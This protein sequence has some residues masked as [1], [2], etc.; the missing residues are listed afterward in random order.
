M[1]RPILQLRPGVTLIELIIV[2]AITAL[3]VPA[4]FS[5]LGNNDRAKFDINTQQLQSSLRLS[6]N[7]AE[8]GI[9]PEPDSNCPGGSS[10]PL[11]PGDLLFG[12]AL[13]FNGAGGTHNDFDFTTE[14]GLVT[15]YQ[16]RR[17]KV[18][19]SDEVSPY[20]A[21][22]KTLP[23]EMGY[24]CFQVKAGSSPTTPCYKSSVFVV[25]Y[26]LSK[27][28]TTLPIQT[29]VFSDDLS[30]S[31]VSDMKTLPLAGNLNGYNSN[32]AQKVIL[33]LKGTKDPGLTACIIINLAAND[34]Q[35]YSG[36]TKCSI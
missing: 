31:R 8:A 30:Y 36:G 18:E 22:N 16:E 23:A 11:Q 33:K 26:K 28:S 21:S 24:D 5:A 17:L 7:R 15:N 10:C 13:H 35:Q 3:M 25:F 34:I 12:E 14:A 20:A 1:K 4:A 32:N 6:L 29:K 2:L 19:A 27:D 9:G